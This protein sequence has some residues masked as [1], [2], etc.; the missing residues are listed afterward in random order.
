M[1]LKKQPAAESKACLCIPLHVCTRVTGIM[2]EPEISVGNS[3]TWSWGFWSFCS[4]KQQAKGRAS[5][6]SLRGNTL[7]GGPR[8]PTVPC[9]PYMENDKSRKMTSLSTPQGLTMQLLWGSAALK[10][11][12]PKAQPHG[13]G[14]L[15][16]CN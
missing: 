5:C 14:H 2:A 3:N 8:V 15:V 10:A 12:N 9:Q 7:P 4:F 13:I 11:A 16:G 6:S 1:A